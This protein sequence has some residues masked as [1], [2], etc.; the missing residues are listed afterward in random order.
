MKRPSDLAIEGAPS[1]VFICSEKRDPSLGLVCYRRVF[2]VQVKKQVRSVVFP[3]GA[4]HQIVSESTSVCGMSK[5]RPYGI[6][7][8]AAKLILTEVWR[9]SQKMCIKDKE[10]CN[11]FKRWEPPP[12]PHCHT[13]PQIFRLSK[14]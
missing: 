6:T 3:H 14:L 10:S 11:I 7:L 5:E 12:I 4:S 2:E 8:R 1:G 13:V 9:Q